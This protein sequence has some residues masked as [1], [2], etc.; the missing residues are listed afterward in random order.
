MVLMLTWEYPVMS[1]VGR[2]YLGST[3]PETPYCQMDRR[4]GVH[5]VNG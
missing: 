2:P 5:T 4:G 1:L 3:S